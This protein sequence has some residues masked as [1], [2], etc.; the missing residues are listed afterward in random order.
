MAKIEVQ[1]YLDF[2][3]RYL[4][5]KMR[6]ANNFV[7]CLQMRLMRSGLQT[8]AVIEEGTSVEMKASV[9]T[10]ARITYLYHKFRHDH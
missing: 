2:N 1:L 6:E 5:K 10:N 9:G 4:S 3:F 7:L 8:N